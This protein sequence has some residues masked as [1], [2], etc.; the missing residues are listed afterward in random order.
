MSH[1]INTVLITSHKN[2]II[3]VIS[4]YKKKKI[5]SYLAAVATLVFQRREKI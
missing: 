1:L 3:H 2:V 4:Y 5:R